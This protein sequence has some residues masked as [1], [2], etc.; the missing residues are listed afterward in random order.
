M[1]WKIKWNTKLSSWKIPLLNITVMSKTT[2]FFPLP[3]FL[4]YASPVLQHCGFYDDI[5]SRGGTFFFFFQ[6]QF[7]IK[8]SKQPNNL[9][10]K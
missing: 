7:M 8:Y 4:M 5:R 9:M 2:Y 6:T 3:H 10:L 1:V